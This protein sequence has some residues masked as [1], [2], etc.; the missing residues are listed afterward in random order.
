MSNTPFGHR[1]T[2]QSLAEAWHCSAR[3]VARI[4]R[5]GLLG[6]PIGKLGKTEIYSDD[7]KIAA[8]KAGLRHE[9]TAA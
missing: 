2:T 1:W 7:Q 9:A 4:K 8:E 5:K 6:D 3:T